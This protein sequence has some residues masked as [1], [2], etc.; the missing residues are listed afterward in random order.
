MAWTSPATWTAG[1]VLNA[2]QL[3]TQVRDNFKAIGDPW[4]AYV[5]QWLG[6]TTNPV[7]GNGSIVAAYM[8]AGK[9]VHFRIRIVMG[10]TTTY[11]SGA[12]TF[13]LPVAAVLSTDSAIDCSVFLKDVSAPA[14]YLRSAYLNTTTLIAPCDAAGALVNST[15]P[16][17]WANTD[18]LSIA[19]TYEAA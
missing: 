9:L 13:G 18:I 2:A 12:W 14:R 4:T 6:A 7:I 5:P 10:S 11:G 19:G 8:Q 16:F 3:N 1:T 15:S 17:V